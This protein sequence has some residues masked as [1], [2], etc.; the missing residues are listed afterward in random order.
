VEHLT[1]AELAEKGNDFLFD[2]LTERVA[3]EPVKLKL[4]VQLA[5]DGDKVDDATLA[6]PDA[7]VVL[8]LGTIELTAPVAADAEEQRHII[9]DPIPRVEGIAP[10][11]DPLLELRAAIY[12]LSGR[13]RRAAKTE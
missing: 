9:F 10:S 2:E 5:E 12:L 8:E 7:R 4:S 13:Q 11:A 3:G 6:W 1:A